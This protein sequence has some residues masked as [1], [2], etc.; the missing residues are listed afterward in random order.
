M[1][2]IDK[3]ISLPQ[4]QH[5]DTVLDVETSVGYPEQGNFQYFP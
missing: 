5:D 4:N 2:I 3:L 1:P